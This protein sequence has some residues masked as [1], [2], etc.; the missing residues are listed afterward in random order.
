MGRQEPVMAKI[1]R[2][3]ISKYPGNQVDANDNSVTTVGADPIPDGK[4]LRITCF[5]GAMAK[6]GKIEL[7]IRTQLGPDKWRTLRCIIGPG[8]GHYE[9]LQ[10]IKGDAGGVAAL[11]IV[12]TNDEATNEKINAWCEGIRR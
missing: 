9:N 7:Q 11:R 4:Q 3:L 8:H 12:R 2:P 5:G 1:P 6:A 10:P